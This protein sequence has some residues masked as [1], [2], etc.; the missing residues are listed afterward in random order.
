MRRV[1]RY[2]SKTRSQHL[3]EDVDG[4]PLAQVV[5]QDAT[6]LTRVLSVRGEENVLRADIEEKVAWYALASAN[7]LAALNVRYQYNAIHCAAVCN[8][9]I[10]IV[11]SM[12]KVAPDLVRFPPFFREKNP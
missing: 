2:N 5:S 1:W 9:D 3:L 11:R 8:A 10:D 4:I 12:L 6:L 7:G